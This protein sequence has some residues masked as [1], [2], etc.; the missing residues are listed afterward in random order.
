MVFGGHQVA[1]EST[2]SK[3]RTWWPQDTNNLKIGV[4]AINIEKVLSIVE[5]I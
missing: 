2:R 3:T 1:F 4:I 5:W